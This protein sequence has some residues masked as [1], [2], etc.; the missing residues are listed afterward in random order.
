MSDRHGPDFLVIGAQKSGTTWL[1]QNLHAHPDIWLPPEKELHFFDSRL[2]SDLGLVERIRGDDPEAERWR[3]QVRRQANRLRADRGRWRLAPWYAR[4]FLGRGGMAWYRG[5]FRPAG[6]RIAG[7][8]TPDY[9]LLEEPVIDRAVAAFPELRLVYLVRNPIERL[10]SHAQME[11]RL[12]GRPATERVLEMATDD[13]RPHDHGDYLAVLDRWSLRFGEERMWLGF[14]EDVSHHPRRVLDEVTDHLGA[15][16]H[17]R[18]PRAGHSVHK[19]GQD[20][21]PGTVATAL[22]EALQDDIVAQANRLGGHARWWRA[23]AEHLL[24]DRPARDLA[25]PLW[26]DLALVDAVGDR[27]HDPDAWASGRLDHVLRTATAGTA[28]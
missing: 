7:E 13:G 28:P 12:T 6:N 5:L 16:R 21:I 22:A 1:H 9:A 4:Y 10:W 24:A 2:T 23:T 25:Y 3:R 19:G 26:E 17:K 18:Y 20:T 15:P 27:E 8:V 11:E 14:M